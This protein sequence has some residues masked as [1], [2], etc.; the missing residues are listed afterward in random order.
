MK[1]KILQSLTLGLFLALGSNSYSQCCPTTCLNTNG[2]METQTAPIT[3]GNTWI[4][5][6]LTNWNV[7]HGDPSIGSTPSTNIWMWSYWHNS[8]YQRGEGVY[9]SYN[10]VAGQTYTICYKLWRDANSNPVST[11]RVELANGLTPYFGGGLSWDFGAATPTSTQ[12]LTI[13]PWVNTGSWVTITETFTANANYSQLW[14]YPL[15]TSSPTPDQAACRID[16]VCIGVLDTD[17][18]NFEPQFDP[19]MSVDGCSL[20]LQDVTT[21]PCFPGFTV[22]GV[23]WD[24]GDGT[25]G[26][27]TGTGSTISHYYQNSGTYLVCMEV[28]VT[29]GD[30]CCKQTFCM[31]IDF[32]ANCEP[33]E[34][35]Q[36]ADFSFTGTGPITFTASG[37]PTTMGY[38]YYWDFGDGN[39]G[40]GISTSHNYAAPGTYVVCLT[41][42]YY[43][44]KTRECCS[45]RVCHEVEVSTTKSKVI[46]DN[47]YTQ[48]VADDI[49]IPAM[50]L[51]VLPNPNDGNFDLRTDDNTEI[52]NVKV[53]NQ[54]GKLV[55]NLDEVLPSTKVNI[56]LSTLGKGMYFIIINETDEMNRKFERVIIE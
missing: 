40:S 29:N 44:E 39:Y 52:T 18:C 50:G 37:I 31:E 43:D 51:T 48:P 10:F 46:S 25:T 1:K 35:M 36:S 32:E 55:Y 42:F 21:Y 12:P 41:V 11:F 26:S 28:W 19:M 5:N 47:I 23:N 38:G 34:V 22:L 13:Q 4:N 45:Y 15:L 17:P 30:I 56:D 7:S 49:A 27:T 20:L 8:G 9:T 16:D 33:C 2:D 53:Y 3:A 54:S 24:F 6:E 14:L